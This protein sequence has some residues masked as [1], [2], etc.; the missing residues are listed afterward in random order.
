MVETSERNFEDYIVNALTGRGAGAW[1]GP[2]VVSTGLPTGDY[3]PLAPAGYDRAHCIHTESLFQFLHASQAA[4]WGKLKK[5]HGEALVKDR[6]LQRLAGE[7][8]KRGTLD[9][10]RK[11]VSD[12]GCKF[13]LA[14]FRPETGLNADHARQ[15]EHNILGVMRQVHYS[16]Q[17]PDRSLDLVLFLN[18]L[19]IFTA[20]LKNPFKGQ[21]IEHAIAQ[22]RQDRDP[23]DPLF[24]FGRCLGHFAVD[25][26][27][28]YLT[29]H[30]RGEATRFLPFN[31]GH[32][33]GAGNPPNPHGYRTAYLWER[34]WA[35]D[36]LLEIL[37]D[38]LQVVDKTDDKGRK[39]GEREL[40]FPRY[41]QWDAVRRLVNDSRQQGAGRHYLIQH[42]AGSGKSNS[43]AWLAHRL[44]GLHDSADSRVFDSI[45]VITDRRALDRQLRSTVRGF[46]QVKNL[47]VA[48]E[49]GS[50]QLREAL[51]AGSNIIV[52]T[53]QKFPFVVDQI[54]KL[55]GKRFAVIIDEAHSSQSGEGSS[56][57]KRVLMVANLD[58]AE[59]ADSA[60][61]P[62]DE[63]AINARVEA[64]M[65]ARTRLPHVSFFAFTATPKNK[66]LELFGTR[67][68]DGSFAPFSL[69][70]MRQAIEENFILDVLQH[71]TTYG[72][73][74]SLLK[75][76]QTDPRYDRA[77]ATTLLQNYAGLHEH[78]IRTKIAVMVEHFH[79]H[80]SG[81][82]GGQ[83]KAMIVTR[84]RLH[85][86]RYKE[87]LERYLKDRGYPYRA[88][89][90]F[91]G[92]VTDPDSGLKFTEA[93]MNGVS[94]LQT[95]D[96]FK[97]QE[98]RFL[99]VANKFQTGFDQPLLHTMYVD[100]KL[101]GVNAVQTLSRLNRMHPGKTDTLVL[102]FAN[103][104]DEIQKAFQ[105]YYETTLLAEAT[106]PN[107]L[108]DLQRMLDEYGLFTTDTIAAFAGV[109]FRPSGKQDQLHAILDPVVAAYRERDTEEQAAFQGHLT[110]YV[111]LYAF[112]SQILPFTDPD[113]EKLYVFA[114]HL[115]R[116]LP[117]AESRLPVEVTRNINMDSYRIQ[118]TGSGTILLVRESGALRPISDLGTAELRTEDTAALSEIVAYINEHFGTDFTDADRLAHFSD[119]LERRMVAHTKLGS[120]LDTV[121]N[122]SAENR[123]LVFNEIFDDILDLMM[124][125]NRDLYKKV[126]DDQEFGG[127]FRA[128]MFRRILERNAA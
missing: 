121:V 119:D 78:A 74:F 54:G 33:G 116:K 23:K 72:V 83:A 46:S 21:T 101:G 48:V 110:D 44:A 61:V 67:Q 118:Q 11:G 51:E 24:L 38:F 47:V 1:Q 105:P 104:A 18:G 22:Y 65:A 122:P 8:A 115:V 40:I 50:A 41:H 109:Y 112:L 92:E 102:D 30:L 77:K 56:A 81:R 89:V 53:L 60:P 93:G 100:K 68:P 31:L 19:P 29:T 126:V 5:Q 106:D 73:Y 107:K 43:I 3:V 39:T 75:R 14:Y 58:E 64:A 25:P 120:A 114:R 4:E 66:T 27:L 71:Y 113:L 98:Y 20:E 94:E 59:A 7:I 88:L 108:Y 42:S 55:P 86:V 128:Y 36:N 85:A 80:T 12:L 70:S 2:I 69:Y 13:D 26:D 52:T 15:Y 62:D 35:R 124:E 96:T 111:R 84:S 37:H 87:A 123:R 125:G 16:A 117:A 28:V 17:H 103:G 57:V 6:F 95:A 79:D 63:D 9:V 97:Q 90:A 49:E 91:S 82:I 127:L 99:V 34:I 10:L 32:A 45:I 76:I